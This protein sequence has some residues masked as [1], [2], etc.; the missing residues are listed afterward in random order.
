MKIKNIKFK[1]YPEFTPNLT[2]KQIMKL[3]AFGGQYWRPIYSSVTKKN[4]KERYKKYKDFDNIN[5]KYLSND[6]YDKQLNKYKVKSGS[7]LELWESKNWI[8]KFDPYGWF[9]WYV[10]F[11]N[12]R[13]CDD[14]ERQIKRWKNIM[15]RFKKR[16]INMINKKNTSYDDYNISPVMRQLLLHWAY[17]IVENDLN[18]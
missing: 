18:D 14:D 16:L 10:N 9:E 1:D 5:I 17:E 6:K 15:I 11:Y 2:P 8:T 7:S 12:G 4:Y 3:G 13:R